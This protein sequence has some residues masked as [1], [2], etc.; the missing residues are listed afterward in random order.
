MKET[1]KG[2]PSH[3]TLLKVSDPEDVRWPGAGLEP[4]RLVL[5][6]GILIQALQQQRTTM[7][8]IAL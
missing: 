7:Y 2:G 1:P 6:R 3:R 4:A 8:D 5:G